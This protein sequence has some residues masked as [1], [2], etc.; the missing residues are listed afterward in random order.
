ME[1]STH[2]KTAEIENTL[3]KLRDDINKTKYPNCNPY[4]YYFVLTFYIY[5]ANTTCVLRSPEISE[6][7]KLD[8]LW[9]HSERLAIGL[10]LASTPKGTDLLL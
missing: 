8:L 9:Q 2:P 6:Q 5:I 3:Q 4:S 10:G 1:D 7:Q